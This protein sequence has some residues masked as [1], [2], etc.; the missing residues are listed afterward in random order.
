[1]YTKR[2]KNNSPSHP[3][4]PFDVDLT[5]QQEYLQAYSL[6]F[7]LKRYKQMKRLKDEFKWTYEQIGSLYGMTRQGV[8]YFFSTMEKNHAS[9]I[10]NEG[11]RR[12]D[13]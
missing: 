9:S 12:D 3:A 1:M 2:M 7:K 10:K 6:A 5:S 11:S 4:V 13:K 8:S